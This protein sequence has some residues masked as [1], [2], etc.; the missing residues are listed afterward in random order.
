MPTNRPFFFNFLAA[1][2][3][4]SALSKSS[5]STTST[6]APQSTYT[7]APPTLARAIATKPP[8]AGATAAA[9]HAANPSLSSHHPRQASTSPS[10]AQPRSPQAMSPPGA[11]GF[12]RARRGSD[13]S[14]E[15]GFRDLGEKWYVGGKTA[16]GEERYLRL[17]M[18][19]K[20]RSG[21]RL[22]LDRL[23]L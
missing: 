8:S 20:E 10:A 7:H 3:A 11:A 9:V 23:S 13:T 1:F 19:R 2:R 17:G 15:G 6:P 22:S 21:D 5:S 12:R 14:S 16:S 18:V 4:Q